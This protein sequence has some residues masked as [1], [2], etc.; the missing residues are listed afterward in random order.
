MS[1]CWIKA[2]IMPTVDHNQKEAAS[3]QIDIELD[4]EIE[5]IEELLE[6]LP[7]SAAPFLNNIAYFTKELDDEL[8]IE[9]CLNDKQ[10]IEFVTRDPNEDIVS[11]SEPELEIVSIKEAA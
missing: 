6:T 1:N 5:E 8:P 9:E 7:N 11:D 2:G 3:D 4:V 10:I